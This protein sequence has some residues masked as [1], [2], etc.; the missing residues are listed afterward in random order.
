MFKNLVKA[1]KQMKSKYYDGLPHF[2]IA[3]TFR[4]PLLPVIMILLCFAKFTG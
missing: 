2:P 1:Q 3:C 4:L